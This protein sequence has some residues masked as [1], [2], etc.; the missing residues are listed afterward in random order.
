MKG[1]ILGMAIGLVLG[2]SGMVTADWYTDFQ[3]NSIQQQQ[4]DAQREQNR[5]LRQQQN[6]SYLN[7]C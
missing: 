5:I 3:R 1:L 4:L 6:N 2:V 7:P